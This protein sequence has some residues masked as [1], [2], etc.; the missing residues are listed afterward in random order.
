MKDVENLVTRTVREVLNSIHDGVYITDR[1]R[2]IVFWNRGAEQITGHSADEVT[3]SRCQDEILR[4]VDKDGRPLCTTELCPLRRTMTTDRPAT[5]Y[6]LY[7]LT[8]SGE[9]VPVSVSTSPL[10][11][12]DGEVVGGI[13]IFRD[14]Q[15]RMR[16]MKL[17]QAV[18]QEMEPEELPGDQHVS[19]AVEAAASGMVGGDYYNVEEVGSGTY[20]FFL[21]DIIGHGVSAALYMSL[22]HSLARECRKLMTEPGSFML[23]LNER[24]CHR[25]PEIGFVTA[26]AGRVDSA[27][28]QVTACSAGHPPTMRQGAGDGEIEM[29]EHDNFPLGVPEAEHYELGELTLARGERLLAYTDGAPETSVGEDELL[30]RDGL[31]SL[32]RKYPPRST[33]HRLNDVYKAIVRGCIN[34]T[35]EDDI[36]LLSCLKRK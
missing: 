19:F 3:G 29:I 10:H 31:A 8:S 27:S 23:A 18:Q 20:A 6:I 33:H 16:D 9:R 32:F 25:L 5:S 14:E 28:G 35:P 22:I 34:H 15:H 12:R 13:E 24:I 1:G 36:T 30:G 2:N 11:N 4:H 21:A 26:V 7:A 17:A